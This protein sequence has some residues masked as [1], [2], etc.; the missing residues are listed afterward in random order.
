M[1]TIL[2]KTIAKLKRGES[3]IWQ[4]CDCKKQLIKMFNGEK[5]FHWTIGNFTHV[6]LINPNQKLSI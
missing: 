2:D 3:I 1:G 5:S 4:F 6:R